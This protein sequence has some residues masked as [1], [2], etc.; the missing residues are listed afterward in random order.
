[1]APDDSKPKAAT[2]APLAKPFRARPFGQVVPFTHPLMGRPQPDDLNDWDALKIVRVIATDTDRIVVI[3]YENT[4]S[5]KR[6]ISRRQIELCVQKGT[7]AEGPCVNSHG[8]WQMNLS[9]H[10]AGEQVICIVAI[11]WATKVLVINSF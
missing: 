9:R 1:M 6:K 3:S 2:A 5:K 4:K 7:I 11:D 8:H 10:A